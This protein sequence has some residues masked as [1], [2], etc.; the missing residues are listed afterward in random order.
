MA[1]AQNAMAE[2]GNAL[3]S[4]LETY[5]EGYT[6]NQTTEDPSDSS[7][8]SILAQSILA[9]NDFED[10]AS[11]QSYYYEDQQEVFVAAWRL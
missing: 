5:S 11:R 9:S 8:D 3:K 7:S 1:E 4:P 10:K 2:E 6:T